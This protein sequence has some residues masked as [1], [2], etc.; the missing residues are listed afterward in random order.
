MDN[1][2]NKVYSLLEQ[3]PKGKV[4]T[5]KSIATC[6]SNKNL[7]RAVGNALHLNTEKLKYPCYKVVNSKGNLSKSYAFGGINEQSK[8][9]I[10]EGI[11]VE[12]N[13][14]DLLKYKHDFN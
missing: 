11:V 5:Y 1:L 4:T 12:N 2:K 8:L 14:V 13:R 10:S 7:A 3:I 9:L 6:L